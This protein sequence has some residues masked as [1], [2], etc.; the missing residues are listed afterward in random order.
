MKKLFVVALSIM[1]GGAL[2]VGC[3]S[4]STDSGGGGDTS[5]PTVTSISELPRATGAMAGASASESVNQSIY[6]AA[7]TG[8]ILSSTV[9]ADF[10]TASSRGACETFNMV[11]EGIF[12]AGMGDQILCYV[13]YM[14]GLGQ[15]AGELDPLTGE[16]V[17]VYDGNWHIFNLNVQSE[18]EEGGAPELIKVQILKDAGG[19]ITSFE[20]F[21]CSL[22]SESELVQTEYTKQTL[23]S[24]TLTMRSIGFFAQSGENNWHSTDVLGNLNADNVF[25]EK[26]ITLANTGTRGSNT[27]WQ[28]ATLTQGPGTFILSGYQS[29]I[30]DDGEMGNTYNN[31]CYA[32]GEMVNDSTADLAVLAMGDGAVKYY[33]AGSYTYEGVTGDYYDPA[34]DAPGVDAWLGDGVDGGKGGLPVSPATDSLYYNAA[35]DGTL[36]DTEA[37]FSMTFAAAEMWNCLDNDSIGIVTMPASDQTA[38]SA[39]C[40]QYSNDN[41]WIDCWQ[42]FDSGDVPTDPVITGSW[43]IVG[44]GGDNCT[45]LNAEPA[46]TY[47]EDPADTWT[48]TTSNDAVT[49]VITKS[50]D[51]YTSVLAVSG[52]TACTA[53]STTVADSNIVMDD[54]LMDGTDH[55]VF[56]FTQ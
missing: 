13:G 34:Q 36:T 12:S 24:S 45:S 6:K 15:F 33:S 27:N 50:G 46:V 17:D 18:S 37:Q 4:S 55:C 28:R 39:A 7:T 16:T 52:E 11:K 21:M 14:D 3:G 9:Q 10:T 40:D 20:M 23:T 35:N 29:G 2:V 30:Y 54:C 22:N 32:E 56:T 47:A 31:Q 51:T 26:T 49:F 5:I 38:M 43:T 53:V 1:F 25:T 8:L 42:V 48:G 44:T 41:S 19:N